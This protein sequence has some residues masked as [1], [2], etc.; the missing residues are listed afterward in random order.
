MLRCVEEKG[1]GVGQ[2]L[3]AITQ[4]CYEGT[5]ELAGFHAAER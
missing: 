2:C 4:T 5:A 3:L 1:D